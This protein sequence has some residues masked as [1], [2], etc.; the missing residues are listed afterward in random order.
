MTCRF[1]NTDKPAMLALSTTYLIS[2]NLFAYCI[3]NSV[4]YSNPNEMCTAAISFSALAFCE[5][6]G[7]LTAIAVADWWNLVG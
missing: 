3:Y 7:W 6:V 5:F 4:M 2:T 1:L